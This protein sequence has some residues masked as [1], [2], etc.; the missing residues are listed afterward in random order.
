MES[1]IQFK[2]NNKQKSCSEGRALQ[3]K[4][5][6][7]RDL[8]HDYKKV[9]AKEKELKHIEYEAKKIKKQVWEQLLLISRTV[10]RLE[11]ERYEYANQMRMMREERDRV[12]RDLETRRKEIAKQEK[13]IQFKLK[14][15]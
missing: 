11:K 5:Q 7:Q 14:K 9:D 15:T 2:I 4:T 1:F 10:E 12:T 3:L 8:D 13:E 6:Y